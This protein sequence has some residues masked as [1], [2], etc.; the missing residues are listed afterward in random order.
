LDQIE[1]QGYN[2]GN[3][4]H[5]CDEEL[6]RFYLLAQERILIQEENKLVEILV[7]NFLSRVN[8]K[9]FSIKR[10]KEVL[11]IYV[12]SI[13]HVISAEQIDPFIKMMEFLCSLFKEEPNK[14]TKD[15]CCNEIIILPG[16][17]NTK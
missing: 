12:S 1:C 9:C 13:L 4:R 17:Y 7:I 10:I 16:K 14:T 15:M 6:Y 5:L 2:V 3:Y 11:T 8:K